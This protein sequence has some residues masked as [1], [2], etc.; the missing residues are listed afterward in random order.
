M[1]DY[2]YHGCVTGFSEADAVTIWQPSQSPMSVQYAE[3]SYSKRLVDM[4]LLVKNMGIVCIPTTLS[5]IP[6]AVIPDD[7][8]TIILRVSMQSN[9]QE[10]FASD[11]GNF[12]DISW[13]KSN[14]GAVNTAE[15]I[16]TYL[17]LYSGVDL[18][19]QM[20]VENYFNF[21]PN[22]S[23]VSLDQQHLGAGQTLNISGI[24]VNEIVPLNTT[25]TPSDIT[26]QFKLIDNLPVDAVD[27]TALQWG[28][29]VTVHSCAVKKINLV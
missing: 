20:S 22:F 16:A 25:L 19:G 26:M 13:N 9:G 5:F 24:S 11:K 6:K 29:D 8:N 14:I 21:D 15:S 23:D 12:V 1:S 18:R 3:N 10:L 27:Y 17:F 28:Q 7:K 4:G 2:E